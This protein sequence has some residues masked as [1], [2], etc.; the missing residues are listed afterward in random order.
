MSKNKKIIILFVITLLLVGSYM[1]KKSLNNE[2]TLAVESL[3]DKIEKA[4]QQDLPM[5]IYFT[6]TGII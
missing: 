3:N 1:I 6:Y 4:Y 2:S 5:V